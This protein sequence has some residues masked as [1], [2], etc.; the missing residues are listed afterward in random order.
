MPSA[1]NKREVSV[2]Q[3]VCTCVNTEATALSDHEN[4]QFCLCHTQ[5][6]KP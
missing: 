5:F 4:G 3:G 6:R 2:A 1:I